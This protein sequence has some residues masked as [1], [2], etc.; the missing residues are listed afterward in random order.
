VPTLRA[1]TASTAQ[2]IHCAR[3]FCARQQRGKPVSHNIFGS[4]LAPRL[5]FAV[6]FAFIAF[7][8]LIPA[9]A[10][11][12]L[13]LTD[14]SSEPGIPV[15]W[16]GIQNY[17]QFFTGGN[18]ADSIGAL[19]HTL[20]FALAVSV[21]LNVVAL[22]VAIL[23][24]RQSRFAILTRSVVFLP[25]VLGVTVVGLLW[26]LFFNPI[27]GPAQAFV[28]LFGVRSSFFGDPN[29][30]LALCIFVQIWM[31][32]GYSALIYT[33]GLQ[34]VPG[35]LYEAASIDGANGWHRLRYV[36]IPMIAPSMTA[37]ILIAIIGSLQSFQLIYVLTGVLNPATSVL[38]LML[39]KIGFGLSGSSGQS[40]GFAS[41]ISIVQFVLVAVIALA[42]YSYLRRRENQL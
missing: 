30:A 35:E 12:A 32:V 24:N 7:F 17:V 6:P 40:Q 4:S 2:N 27:G 11:I 20:I 22:A 25:T 36:T 33:S 21:I 16:V 1:R 29:L 9:V 13:S 42:A 5:G 31:S 41:A 34:A 8:S 19:E 3:P 39:F 23:L 18:S 38:S 15:H 28:G 10:T 37:N 26:S 14:L